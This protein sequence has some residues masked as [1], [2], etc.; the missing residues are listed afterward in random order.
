MMPEF[1]TR[2]IRRVTAALVLVSIVLAALLWASRHVLEPF[3]PPTV[4]ESLYQAPSGAVERVFHRASA[5]PVIEGR[6]SARSRPA[7]LL[8]VETG[9]QARLYGYFSGIRPEPGALVSTDIP[10]WLEQSLIHLPE[11]SDQVLIVIRDNGERE[12]IPVA[13]VQRLYHPNRL[14]TVERFELLRERLH[15]RITDENVDKHRGN[16]FSPPAGPQTP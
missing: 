16:G 8:A 2:A 1:L 13:G 15:R 4:A 11:D 14:T 5:E 6:L 12:E 10:P 7:S 3:W 9:G